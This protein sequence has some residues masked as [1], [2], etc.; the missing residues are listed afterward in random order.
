MSNPPAYSVRFHSDN[1]SGVGVAPSH[2]VPSGR[3]WVI[4]DVQ[5]R[6]PPGANNECILRDETAGQHIVLTVPASEKQGSSW[7]G[8]VV[9]TGPRSIHWQTL[10]AGAQITVCGY[11]LATAG[12][13]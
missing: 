3:T 5:T 10:G 9:L 8:R 13:P 12:T 7:E 2:T 11:D 6:Q 1:I 4:R